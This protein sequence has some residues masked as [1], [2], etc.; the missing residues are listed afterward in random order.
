MI[1]FVTAGGMKCILGIQRDVSW[2][3]NMV[4]DR[5]GHFM[6]KELFDNSSQFMTNLSKLSVVWQ[7]ESTGQ[8]Y[9]KFQHGVAG[10]K[11]ILDQ[12]MHLLE[13]TG[14]SSDNPY[15]TLCDVFNDMQLGSSGNLS[16]S[17]ISC[18]DMLKKAQAVIE[19]ITEAQRCSSG[20]KDA[21]KAGLSDPATMSSVFSEDRRRRALQFQEQ[22]EK[23]SGIKAAVAQKSEEIHSGKNSQKDREDSRRQW[24][25]AAERVMDLKKHGGG[26]DGL[27]PPLVVRPSF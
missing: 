6:S 7:M 8:C 14:Q 22:M 23:I 9:I 10:N 19:D 1:P 15:R 4:M 27:C 5:Q 24:R 17:D 18:S 12:Y 11:G 3:I 21:M 26:D 2:L 16:F 13:F 25:L 20:A